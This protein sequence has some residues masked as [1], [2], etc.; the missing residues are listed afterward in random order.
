MKYLVSASLV[1]AILVAVTTGQPQQAQP[2]QQQQRRPAA[3]GQARRTGA[4]AGNNLELVTLEDGTKVRVKADLTLSDITDEQLNQFMS[5]KTAVRILVKCFEPRAECKIKAAR[6]L[7]SDVRK[8]GRGGVCG[9]EQCTNGQEKRQVERLVKRAI[10]I[11]Q[12]RH[13]KEWRQLI[14]NIAFLL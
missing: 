7:V 6:S 11:L 4:Q 10:A 2:R 12:K 9:G 13:R 8:L 5:R 3:Q 1:L 14:P